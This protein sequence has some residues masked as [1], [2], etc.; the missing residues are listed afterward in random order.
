MLRLNVFASLELIKI[1]AE[2]Q[3]CFFWRS[4]FSTILP[5]EKTA[6]KRTVLSTTV[7]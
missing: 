4:F 3:H 7:S 6:L 1:F 2:E 5:K